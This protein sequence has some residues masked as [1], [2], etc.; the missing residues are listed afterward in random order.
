MKS[1]NKRLL[2]TLLFLLAVA[3]AVGL[4]LV[5]GPLAPVTV[6]TAQARRGD[7]HPARFGVGTV[8]A[9][10]RY[11]L[12]PNRS[13]RLLALSVDHG[14]RV[15][16]GQV[17]GTLDPVDLDERLR[18]AEMA[19]QKAMR[20]IDGARARLD[21]LETRLVL[22]AK[23]ASRYR[24]L[25]RQK[26]VSQDQVDAKV[27]ESRALKDQLR[28]ARADLEAARHELE[29]A[30]AERDAVRAQ[31]EDLRLV[32]PVDGLVVERKVEPGS[33]VMA[34]TP[35]LVIV[36]P[37]SLWVRTRI[38]QKGSG[39]LAVGLPAEIRLREAPERPLPGRVARLELVADS[40]T[41][42][43]W[44]D[45]AFEAIPGGLAVGTLANV[46]LRLP[47]VKGALWIPAAALQWREG[48]T[49]VWLLDGGRATFRAVQVGVRTLDGKVQILEGLAEGEAVITHS[50][51]ALE[52]GMKLK[53]ARS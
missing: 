10:Y 42:E 21:E 53:E 30:R 18:A 38:D 16:K 48:R 24:E 31:I 49:G 34:G 32:S 9:R 36:D 22:A 2:Y 41:E 37:A 47:E 50:R 28:A 29:R 44:V 25:G 39:A 11:D 6:E 46:T 15:R 8:E 1:R 17:L 40:L 52:E 27:T 12:G 19:V 13:G 14:D 3:A 20:A 7:L 5:K 45:V 35:V 23:E 43:R 33:V 51:R 26:Q 4:I